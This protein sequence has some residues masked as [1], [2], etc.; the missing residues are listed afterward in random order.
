M[1]LRE[2]FYEKYN[3]QNFWSLNTG[4]YG[5]S[6]MLLDN[7]PLITKGTDELDLGLLLTFN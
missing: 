2:R 3:V 1:M 6:F 5:E 7:S 4:F